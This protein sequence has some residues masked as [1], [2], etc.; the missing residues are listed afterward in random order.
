MQFLYQPLTWGFLLIGVPILIHLINMLRHRK[1]QWAA[2]DFLLESHKRNRR[3]VT[4]KQWLLLA[5]RI[6]AMLL[7]VLMLAKWISASQWLSWIGGQTTNHYVLLDDSLSMSEVGEGSNSSTGYQQA[8]QALNGLVRSISKQQGQH[9]LTLVRW[10]RATLALDASES[11]ARLDAAADLTGVSVPPSPDA[12]LERINSTEPT[13]LALSPMPALQLINPLIAE[14]SGGSNEVYLFSD[15]RRNEFAQP[16]EVRNQLLPLEQNDAKVHLIDCA[17]LPGK[18]LSL[19]SLEPEQEVWATGVPLMVRFQVRN[20][21]NQTARNVI[22][23]LKA[24][25]YGLTG[26]EPRVDRPYSG[27]ALELPAVVI[28]EIGAGETVSRQAQVIFGVPGNHAVEATIESDQLEMDNRRWCTVAIKQSQRVLL[29]DGEVDQSNAF[30]IENMVRPNPNVSTGIEVEKRD[31]SYL[32]D[33]AEESL[34]E[35]DSIALLDVPRIDEQGIEKLESYCRSGGG[36]LFIGGPNT[37]LRFV[38][39]A[40]YRGGDGFFPTQLTEIREFQRFA[41]EGPQVKGLSHPIVEPLLQLQTSPFGLVEI[42]SMLTGSA[43]ELK[44]TRTILTGPLDTPLLVEKT[45]GDGRVLCLLTGL[46]PEWSTFA[47]DPTFVVISLRSLGYLGSFR[48]PPTSNPVG[49]PI[50]MFS[51]DSVLPD[52]DVLIPALDE[53]VRVRLQRPVE[54]GSNGEGARLELKID[55]GGESRS[56]TENLLRPGIFEASM[57][58]TQ[59]ERIFHTVAHNVPAAEG[60]LERVSESELRQ[61]LNGITFDLKS[62][63]TISQLGASSSESSRSTLLVCLLAALLLGEQFLAYATS[64]HAPAL[65]VR[66]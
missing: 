40:L 44:N 46:T 33:V 39:E 10:S 6:L 31:A 54:V 28:E 64:Y 66:G 8:I 19:V 59:G 24:I 35:F 51:G 52:G 12:L 37:N 21:T 62:A 2:M 45:L 36:L 50:A 55:V 47:R 4:F 63:S 30:F 20:R 22:V 38:N 34:A 17:G 56:L 3:W 58:N 25:T 9:Q 1:V 18:N 7:L 23:R 60:D 49:S 29:I 26:V 61:G 48:R 16:D 42:R 13:S 32:R 27:E 57:T 5:S 65:G 15:F 53:G 14:N 43:S 41:D 11:S